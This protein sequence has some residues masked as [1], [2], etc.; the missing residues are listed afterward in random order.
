M[1]TK[2]LTRIQTLKQKQ[3]QYV[4]DAICTENYSVSAETDKEKLQFL[5]DTFKKEYLYEQTLKQYGSIQRVFEEWIKGLPSSFNIDY[6][7][8]NIMQ[9]GVEWGILKAGFTDKQM[10]QFVMSWW[11]RIFMIVRQLAHKNKIEI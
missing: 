5:I 4:L 9:I 7:D 11:T 6:S 8:Y 10:D 1:K 2:E 3:M